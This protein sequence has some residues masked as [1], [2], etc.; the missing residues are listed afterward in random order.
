MEK[1]YYPIRAPRV[2]GRTIEVIH[3]VKLE[4]I[5][6]KVR[7]PKQHRKSSGKFT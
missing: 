7:E 4:R 2:F 3:P 5:D 1:K 6:L